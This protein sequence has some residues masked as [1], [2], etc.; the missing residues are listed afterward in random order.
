MALVGLDVLNTW[1]ELWNE[2]KY[3]RYV[4][5]HLQK[6]SNTAEIQFW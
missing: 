4:W 1:V 3:L 6:E 2:E 5:K